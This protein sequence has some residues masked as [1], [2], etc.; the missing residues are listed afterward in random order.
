MSITPNAPL[1]LLVDLPGASLYGAATPTEAPDALRLAICDPSGDVLVPDVG[2]RTALAGSVEDGGMGGI[3]FA[4]ATADLDPDLLDPRN[5]LRVYYGPLA[6]AEAL[7]DAAPPTLD[8][9]G[10]WQLAISGRGS[11]AALDNGVLYPEVWAD[12][13]DRTF[14]YSSTR[15]PYPNWY[16][17]SEWHQPSAINVRSSYRW[18]YANRKYPKGWPEQSASWMWSS[19]P[20]AGS[21]DGPRWFRAEFNLPS[22]K[23]VRIWAAG[24]DTLQLKV[25]GN[26]V[27]SVGRGGWRKARSITMVLEAGDHVIAARVTNLP[28][29][30]TGTNRSGF[31]FAMGQLDA[32][33][34]VVYWLLRSNAPKWRVSKGPT[35]GWYPPTIMSAHIAEGTARSVAVYP[36]ITQSFTASKDSSGRPWVYRRDVTIPV[37]APG[38][39]IMEVIRSYGYDIQMLPGLVLA[40]WRNR[41]RDLR[42]L[43]HLGRLT[44]ATYSS[45][46]WSRIKTWVLVHATAG[47]RSYATENEDLIGTYGR[48]EV[49]FSGG[50]AKT[51]AAAR[52]QGLGALR[53]VGTPEET[54]DVTTT[55]ASLDDPQPFRDYQVSDIVSV[56]VE[57]RW[58][59]ARVKA[60]GFTENADKTVTWTT[61]VYP[62][63]EG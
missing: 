29:D 39:Q 33:G 22:K 30:A 51:F 62:L 60:I 57:G 36:A 27:M 11:E 7:L 54:L 63:Q 9:K 3:N 50:N 47:W 44:N 61:T 59:A 45:R 40:A 32:D 19:N 56:A 34:Q 58:I 38:S 4:V 43:V 1:D 49:T 25:D 10:T 6:I 16:V 12:N 28:D 8:D 35:P 20:E 5:L 13:E 14:D 52:V 26:V 48:R 31:I 41:S 21:P 15:D 24:D 17:P 37:G 23:H 46:T 55:T 53:D 42:D 18:T 2:K